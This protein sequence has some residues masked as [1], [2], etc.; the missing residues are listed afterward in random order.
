MFRYTHPS[1]G[2]VSLL[3]RGSAEDMLCFCLVGKRGRLGPERLA[4]WV[5]ESRRYDLPLD[6]PIFC[7][8][9]ELV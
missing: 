8:S 1:E 4:W 6:C 9:E 5:T 3:G 7:A 2:L